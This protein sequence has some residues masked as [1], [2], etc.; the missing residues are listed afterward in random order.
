MPLLHSSYTPCLPQP[1]SPSS[2][3]RLP[4][5]I[6]AGFATVT[7]QI[8]YNLQ[9]EPLRSRQWFK[10]RV[11]DGPQLRHISLTWCFANGA[12]RIAS[13]IVYNPH[14][15]PVRAEMWFKMRLVDDWERGCSG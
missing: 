10:M 9:N 13:K 12:V 4:A 14:F 6:T 5:L 2:P 1:V 3:P 15:E 7:F 8:V 11:V